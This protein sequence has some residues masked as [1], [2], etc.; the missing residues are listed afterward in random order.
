MVGEDTTVQYAHA[1]I[2]SV[3]VPRQQ[4]CMF[5]MTCTC[6]SLVH[7]KSHMRSLTSLAVTASSSDTPS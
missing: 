2:N 3:K 6:V 5:T 1:G 4:D 7:P